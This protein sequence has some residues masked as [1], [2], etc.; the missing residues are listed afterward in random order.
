[1]K[2]INLKKN[3]NVTGLPRDHPE[4]YHTFMFENFFK[5]ID[6]DPV[7]VHILDGNAKN[8]QAECDNF[9]HKI[10]EAGGIRLF[11]GGNFIAITFYLIF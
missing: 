7:N 2:Y 4:S 5:H 11:I 6:I 1:M 3:P 10:S 8:L 9:E